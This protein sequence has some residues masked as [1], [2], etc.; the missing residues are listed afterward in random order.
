[1]RIVSGNMDSVGLFGNDSPKSAV[2]GIE[3]AD[4]KYGTFIQDKAVPISTAVAE[5][6]YSLHIQTLWDDMVLNQRSLVFDRTFVRYLQLWGPMRVKLI[7]KANRTSGRLTDKPPRKIGGYSGIRIVPVG[8]SILTAAIKYR[9][10]N[11]LFYSANPNYKLIDFACRDK[12]GRILAFQATTSKRHEA[13]VNEIKI[14]EKEVGTRGLMLYYLH[15]HSPDVFRT[16]P[17]TPETQFCWIFHVAIPKPTEAS[18][19]QSE[20]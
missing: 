17:P 3:S 18:P 6:V 16:T 20:T 9:T 15:P 19:S 14:L 10:A 13:D 7:E 5:K 1:M 12:S 11:I 4:S 8:E 2:I